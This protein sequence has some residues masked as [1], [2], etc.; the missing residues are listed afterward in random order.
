MLEIRDIKIEN[1]HSRCWTDHA[2]PEEA[3]PMDSDIT[4]R[5]NIERLA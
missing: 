1:C 4:D 2:T 5:R 3:F